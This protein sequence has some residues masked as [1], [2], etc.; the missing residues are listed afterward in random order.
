MG[1]D[2]LVIPVSMGFDTIETGSR[3]GLEGKSDAVRLNDSLILLERNGMKRNDSVLQGFQP[4]Q[5]KLIHQNKTSLFL[6]KAERTQELP[7]PRF[8]GIASACI[9]GE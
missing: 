2:A 3:H 9:H 7:A 8:P 6:F 1:R 5:L 4:V